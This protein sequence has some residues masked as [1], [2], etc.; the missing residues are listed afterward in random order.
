MG[1]S[2]RQKQKADM[3]RQA[4]GDARI[5]KRQAGYQRVVVGR[6]STG[7]KQ[8]SRQYRGLLYCHW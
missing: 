2:S 6:C 1:R 8:R 7:T 3:N 5:A 4:H